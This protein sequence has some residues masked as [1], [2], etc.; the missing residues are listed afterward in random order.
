MAMRGL[1]LLILGMASWPVVADA[2][3]CEI[4]LRLPD[5]TPTSP[6]T[7]PNNLALVVTG[8]CAH[9]DD[10]ALEPMDPATLTVYY[11]D[12]DRVEAAF[13]ERATAC[14]GASALEMDR[15]LTPGAY[16][17]E[18]EPFPEVSPGEV[19]ALSF[20]VIQRTAH[21]E[22]NAACGCASSGQGGAGALSSLLLL[23][24][25]LLLPRVRDGRLLRSGAQ[26]RPSHP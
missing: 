5:C 12:G 1:Y 7:V 24:L 14:E 22:V 23:L 4:T 20:T 17:L 19:E 6:D 25:P 26:A 9:P 16:L 10:G 18:V 21:T 2:V 8:S 11:E 13:D 15:L 3:E